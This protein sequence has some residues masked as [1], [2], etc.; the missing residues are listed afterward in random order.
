MKQFKQRLKN[1]LLLVGISAPIFMGSIACSATDQPSWLNEAIIKKVVAADELTHA[2]SDQVTEIKSAVTYQNR[3]KPYGNTIYRVSV[4]YKLTWNNGDGFSVQ[5]HD[6]LAL[7]KSSRQLEV[8]GDDFYFLKQLA[9]QKFVN[10][11]DRKNFV[12]NSY[13]SSQLVVEC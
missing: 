5:H 10:F 4:D 11:E 1:A 12:L 3:T 7:L 8:F 13:G 2:I 6:Y 9:Q